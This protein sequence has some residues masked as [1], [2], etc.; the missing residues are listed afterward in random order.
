MDVKGYIVD[1]RGDGVDVKGDA[2]DVK[3]DALN[4]KGTTHVLTTPAT[5]E[6]SRSLFCK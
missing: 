2:V 5:T 1:A 3:G 6:P 4:V